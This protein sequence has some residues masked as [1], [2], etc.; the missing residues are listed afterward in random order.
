MLFSN[1]Q[2]ELE[3]C[4]LERW[5]KFIGIPFFTII[6]ILFLSPYTLTFSE[7]FTKFH[8]LSHAVFS[9]I[10]VASIWFTTRW[11][12]GFFWKYCKNL[13][14]AYRLGLQIVVSC[15]VSV[16]STLAL[17]IIFLK[18]F[19][20]DLSGTLNSTGYNFIYKIKNL[21]VTVILFTFLINT[22]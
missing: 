21:L 4:K 22:I 10:G 9:L 12:S 17:V 5:A 2:F 8:F 20:L 7:H 1:N 3:F 13:A 16:F 19:E 6:C 14:F 11:I 18:Y 15:I